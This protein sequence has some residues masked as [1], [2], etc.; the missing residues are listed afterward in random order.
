MNELG[1]VPPPWTL[2]GS[3]WIFLYRFPDS[4]AHRESGLAT[5]RLR[6]RGGFG[7]VM[8]V[9]Y[10]DSDV[11]PYDELLIIPGRTSANG[12][13]GYTVSRIYVSTQASVINGRR[14]WGI[15]KELADFHWESSPD[16]SQNVTAAKDGAQFLR[17]KARPTRLSFPL[18]TR[19]F[20]PQLLQPVSE[21]FLATALTGR[22]RGR[23]AR[24][25]SLWIDAEHFPDAAQF[26]P[27]VAVRITG[28]QLTF[29]K[30]RQL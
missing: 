13:Q 23:L 25:E 1:L 24:L 3:G 26:A 21:G 29:P 17:M 22:G 16:G 15:P 10:T 2:R 7:A 12:Y 14:N 19:L 18:S 6:F 8:L 5:N 28:F 27:T 20:S 4:F 9:N 11:G 30:P